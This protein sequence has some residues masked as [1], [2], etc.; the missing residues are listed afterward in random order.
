MTLDPPPPSP[1]ARSRGPVLTMVIGGIMAFLGL[2]VTINGMHAA[3]TCNAGIN[4]F[5]NA[6]T[7]G[8]MCTDA[9]IGTA[10]GLVLALG[11]VITLMAGLA[12]RG[13]PH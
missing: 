7:G 9:H 13:Q 12:R 10:I 6:M 2:I 1:P 5:G 8:Q 4:A 11:G 3:S